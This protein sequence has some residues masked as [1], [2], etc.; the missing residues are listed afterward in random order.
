MMDWLMPETGMRRTHSVDRGNSNLRPSHCLSI[1]GNHAQGGN[2][3]RPGPRIHKKTKHRVFLT[4]TRHPCE[5]SLQ[6]DDMTSTHLVYCALVTTRVTLPLMPC[7]AEA[8]APQVAQSRVHPNAR[9][10]AV[11]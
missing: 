1:V 4:C 9:K 11:L 10:I 8:S 7:R 2:G 3:Q 6:C 5:R